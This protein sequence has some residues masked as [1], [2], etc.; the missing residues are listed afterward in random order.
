MLYLL[1]PRHHNANKADDDSRKAIPICYPHML[2]TQKLCILLSLLQHTIL[3]TS[4]CTAL[5]AHVSHSPH[6]IINTL[7]AHV[8]HSP[9]LIIN[10]LTAHVSHSLHLVMHYLHMFYTQVIL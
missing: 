5:T 9:H 10:P 4:S 2:E 8:S 3:V 6:L 7:T 1:C